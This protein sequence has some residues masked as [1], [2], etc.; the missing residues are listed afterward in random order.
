MTFASWRS[1]VTDSAAL[2]GPW[3]NL[4]HCSSQLCP[5][6]PTMWQRW[7]ARHEGIWLHRRWFCSPECF[8]SGLRDE[9]AVVLRVAVPALPQTNRIPLGLV[10]V[11]QGMISSAQ[12]QHALQAQRAA[13]EGKIGEW[14]MRLGAVS[15]AQV[16]AALAAQ[17]GCPVF[18]ATEVQPL[19]PAMFLP[20]PLAQQFHAVPVFYSR[21]QGSLYV[22]HRE[23][24]QHR[25]LTALEHMLQCRI[26]P[27]ILA[28]DRFAIQ[29]ERESRLA[30]EH[31]VLI[32][33]RQ[34]V[35][36]LVSAILTYAEQ[37]R[38]E[39]CRLTRC[40]DWLWGR[41]LRP[42]GEHLDLLLRIAPEVPEAAREEHL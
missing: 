38:G 20:P 29:L 33:Q 17:Q 34:T 26:E 13:G 25:F 35:R 21:P 11:A 16:T 9:L 31:A 14:L 27:C 24:V 7:W 10:M 5:R 18:A 19:P 3:T 36:E 40:H 28:A 22:G 2:P 15:E 42:E 1:A 6:P 23:A 39:Y 4:P 8:E 12:L 30:E 37:F 41:L 32:G